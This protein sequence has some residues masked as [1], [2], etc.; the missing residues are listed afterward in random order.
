[1]VKCEL[2]LIKAVTKKKKKKKRHHHQKKCYLV[3]LIPHC[4]PKACNSAWCRVGVQSY[5]HSKEKDKIMFKV[6]FMPNI[7]ILK[8]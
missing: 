5:K 3:G 8:F 4:I 1:M 7:L 6:S 2:Q